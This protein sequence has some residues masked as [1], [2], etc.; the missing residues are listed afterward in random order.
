MFR[1]SISSTALTG[2]DA[3][4]LFRITGDTFYQD[5]SFVATLRAMLGKR[6][7]DDE[8]LRFSVHN[9]SI[10]A[11]DYQDVSDNEVVVDFFN[12]ARSSNITIY[13]LVPPA[14]N[15]D[16]A[17][18]ALAKAAPEAPWKRIERVTRKFRGDEDA[19]FRVLCFVNPEIKSV[20]LVTERMNLVKL[21]ALECAIPT[22]FPWYFS[23]DLKITE[24]EKNQLFLPLLKALCADNPDEYLNII[25]EISKQYNIREAKI[26]RLLGDFEQKR[27]GVRISQLTD[28]IR[29]KRDFIDMKLEEV[30]K[31]QEQIEEQNATMLG[32]KTAR[33][34]GTEAELARYFASDPNLDL[35]DVGRNTVDFIARGIID[36]PSPGTEDVIEDFDTYLYEDC[37]GYD[38]DDIHDLLYASLVTQEIKLRT[39][40]RIMLQFPGGI[41]SGRA[42]NY[43]F[44]DN[45]KY[46]T[47]MPNV[48]LNDYDCFGDHRGEIA[49]LTGEGR[50]IEAIAQCVESVH[51]LDLC[52]SA[53]GETFI[54]RIVGIYDKGNV[55]CFELPN[56]EIVGPDRAIQYLKERS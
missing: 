39:C 16:R 35:L 49:E 53:V 37:N 38:A 32:L 12:I 13:N 56:G 29:Q 6:M 55:R 3:D 48:H 8:E 20:L 31:L 25:E 34:T 1:D 11:G 44:A 45:P 47:Y 18:E 51:S 33:R 27:L 43:N 54:R 4:Y 41:V 52:D 36:S 7:K 2:N 14:K 28:E 46:N 50:Y 40:G 17:F 19:P 42:N 22:Y 24:E 5:V 30:R 23:G 26:Q 9:R 21:H 10:D 15:N